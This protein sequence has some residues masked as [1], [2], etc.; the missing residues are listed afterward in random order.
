[1]ATGAVSKL[2]ASSTVA[3]GTS[4]Y[5]STDTRSDPSVASGSPKTAKKSAELNAE[6][7]A[8]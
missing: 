6:V 5:S 2:L 3:P 7:E 1:M 8:R 4:W